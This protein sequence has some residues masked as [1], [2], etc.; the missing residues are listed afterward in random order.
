MATPE[1]DQAG[2]PK[3]IEAYQCNLCPSVFGFKFNAKRHFQK[4]HPGCVFDSSKI[5]NIQ[6]NCYSCRSGFQS[7]CQLEQHFLFAH[8]G[9]GD[10]QGLEAEKV[11]L[12]NTK[13]TAASFQS[14][15]RKDNK[16][17][18]KKTTQ[19]SSPVSTPQRTTVRSWKLTFCL[20]FD[21]F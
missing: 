21:A 4:A 18:N 6:F 1:P 11:F 2:G 8:G 16:K 19:S 17:T 3:K 5:F 20:Q 12:G 7:F 9:G 15:K 10:G 14:F 13:V